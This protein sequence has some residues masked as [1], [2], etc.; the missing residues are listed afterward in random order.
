MEQT[1]NLPAIR[2]LRPAWNKVRIVGQKRPLKPKHVWAIQHSFRLKTNPCGKVKSVR[3]IAAFS[4]LLSFAAC[5][6][7]SEEEIAVARTFFPFADRPN[8]KVVLQHDVQIIE[9]TVYH[10]MEDGSPLTFHLIPVATILE[11]NTYVISV[12]SVLGFADSMSLSFDAEA[13]VQAVI[14]AAKTYCKQTGYDRVNEGVSIWI[15]KNSSALVEFC[16]PDS[17]QLPPFAKVGD[18]APREK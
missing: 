13:D 8:E 2:A 17:V 3:V 10:L 9:G 7:P 14:A 6:H 4:M 18:R 5:V 1:L 12:S 15:G 11:S 16:I